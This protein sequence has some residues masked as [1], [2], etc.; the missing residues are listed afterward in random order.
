MDKHNIVIVGD[1]QTVAKKI[2][3]TIQETGI[4]YLTGIFHFGSLS[5]DDAAKSMELFSKEV[6][7]L[8]NQAMIQT[9]APG[10]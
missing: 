7:P 10:T 5:I 3:Q 9:A 4:N 8:V 2:I 1:P 6:I